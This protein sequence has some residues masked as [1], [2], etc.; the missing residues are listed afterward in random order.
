MIYFSIQFRP[1]PALEQFTPFDGFM[2]LNDA[3]EFVRYTDTDGVT[4]IGGENSPRCYIVTTSDQPA[5]T[6]AWGVPPA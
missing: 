6:P 3:M 1:D 5:E 2:E 4:Q